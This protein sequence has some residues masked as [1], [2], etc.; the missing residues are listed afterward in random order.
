M[1]YKKQMRGSHVH[2]GSFVLRYQ[3]C[4]TVLNPPRPQFCVRQVLV[5]ENGFSADG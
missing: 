4:Y 1:H 3:H 5:D 2:I